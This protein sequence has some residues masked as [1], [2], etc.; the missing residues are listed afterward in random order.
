MTSF[1]LRSG[2]KEI[3]RNLDRFAR[4]VTRVCVLKGFSKACWPAFWP[5]GLLNTVSR[6]ESELESSQSGSLMGKSNV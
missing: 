5:Q 1:C 4:T 3:V 2:S 6:M